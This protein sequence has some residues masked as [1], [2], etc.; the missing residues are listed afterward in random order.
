MAKKKKIGSFTPK[1]KNAGKSFWDYKVYILVGI[2]IILGIL[3]FVFV[4]KSLNRNPA[5][6]QNSP[7]PEVSVSPDPDTGTL[8]VETN[9]SGATAQVLK[10]MARTPATFRGLKEGRYIVILRYY[11]QK[12]RTKEVDVKKNETTKLMVDLKE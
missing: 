1:D 5:L 3:L 9:P 12:P 11:N 7:T 4:M 8:I 2:I 10:Q 6:S